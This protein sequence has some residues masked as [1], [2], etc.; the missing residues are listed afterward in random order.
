MT[1]RRA[2]QVPSTQLARISYET[3]TQSSYIYFI[4]RAVFGVINHAAMEIMEQ[5]TV[6]VAK[7]NFNRHN[8]AIYVAKKATATIGQNTF[9]NNGQK[10]VYE[11]KNWILARGFQKH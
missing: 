10:I 4:P 9:E 6:T 2:L 3:V 11:K 7:N 5:S 8:E 1:A